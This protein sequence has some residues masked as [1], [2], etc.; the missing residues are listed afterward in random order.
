MLALCWC[1]F[2]FPFQLACV[3]WAGLSVM[4]RGLPVIWSQALLRVFVVSKARA[5]VLMPQT[6]KPQENTLLLFLFFFS[7]LFMHFYQACCFLECG[8]V[9]CRW[10]HLI[11]L[12]TEARGVLCVPAVLCRLAPFFWHAWGEQQGRTGLPCRLWRCCSWVGLHFPVF[13]VFSH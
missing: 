7:F 6:L 13:P 11:F 1:E 8:L 10:L 4:S 5:G 12:Q 2:T 3:F 9:S